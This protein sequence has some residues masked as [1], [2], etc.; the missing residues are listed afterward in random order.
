LARRGGCDVIII[1]SCRVSSPV[2]LESAAGAARPSHSSQQKPQPF[3]SL[4]RRQFRKAARK[5]FESLHNVSNQC[6][7]SG[8]FISDPDFYPSRITTSIHPGSRIPDPTTAI[9]EE[10]KKICCP[11]F[12]CSLKLYKIEN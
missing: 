9:E 4:L 1:V 5:T 11:T 10:G 12:F 8:M 7:G 2:L 6:F 3:F